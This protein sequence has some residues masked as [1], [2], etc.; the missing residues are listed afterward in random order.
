M[1]RTLAITDLI[2][3]QRQGVPQTEETSALSRETLD[4]LPRWNALAAE[5][6]E[7]FSDLL[8]EKVVGAVELS[9]MSE[10]EWRKSSEK[11][12]LIVTARRLTVRIPEAKAR[13][14]TDRLL[15]DP[16]SE[17]E[18]SVDGFD[19]LSLAPLLTVILDGIRRAFGIALPMPDLKQP[20]FR[21]PLE[22]P[23]PAKRILAEF[24]LSLQDGKQVPLQ[25]LLP[26]DATNAMKPKETGAVETR[27]LHIG[28]PVEAVL[29]RWTA[30][31]REV[32][33][34]EPGMSLP[35]PGANLD[36]IEIAIPCADQAVSVGSGKLVTSRNRHSIEIV[37]APSA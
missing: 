7:Q 18:P 21:W 34:L 31:A 13:L 36:A 14:L 9:M 22:P 35:I 30:T 16:Q 33:A 3:A 29:G 23:N 19:A 28:L 11:P 27:H 32:A 24:Q 37:S 26:A 25:L 10:R 8:C 5:I 1:A 6:G 17:D 4:S 15:R 20:Q 12:G 2:D